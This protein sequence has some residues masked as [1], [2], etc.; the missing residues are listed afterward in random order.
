[1]IHA[2]HTCI[3]IIDSWEIFSILIFHNPV[4]ATFGPPRPSPFR[5][6]DLYLNKLKSTYPSNT[7]HQIL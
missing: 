5:P 1:M 4:F 7:A 2:I 3:S 6:L